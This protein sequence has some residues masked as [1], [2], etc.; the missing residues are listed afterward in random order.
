ME[1]AR[2]TIDF[3]AHQETAR[4]RSRR[5]VVM[6]IAAVV[7]ICGAVAAVAW[8]AA[9][10]VNDPRTE[11][12]ALAL[13]AGI[14]AL[15]TALTIIGGTLYRVAELRGGGATVAAAMGGVRLNASTRDADERR[16]LNVVEEMAIASGVPVP[17]VYLLPEEQGINAF[18]AGYHTGDAVIGVTRGCVQGLT[19]DELQGVMAH[20]FSHILNGDMRLNIRLIGLLYGIVLLSMTG[21]LIL[22]FV[23]RG[24]M[25]RRS[26]D[27]GAVLVAVIL[28]GITLVVIGAVGSLAARIIQAA[29][30]RQREFLADAA[31]VQFTRNPDGIAGAL[32]RIGGARSR[33]KVRHPRAQ[34]AGHMFFGEAIAG[35]S[36][37]GSMLASHP[38]LKERIGRVLP[39]WD[40]TML[41]PLVRVE[42]TAARTRETLNVPGAPGAGGGVPAGAAAMLPLLA[43]A[44]DATPAHVAHAR[45]LVA[46]IPTELKEAAHEAYGA[47]AVVYALLLDKRQRVRE[48]QQKHLDACADHG[49]AALTAVLAPKVAGLG[50]EL[51]LPLLEMALG[52]LADLSPEQHKVFR[53]NMRSLAEMDGETNIFEW[54]LLRVVN[55]HLDERFGGGKRAVTQYYSLG[56]LGGPVSVL[57]SAVAFAGAPD[58]ARAA[59]AF[60][61]GAGALDGVK[62]R[63]VARAACT[64]STLEEALTTLETVAPRLKVDLLKA[65]AL[66]AAA[67][68]TISPGEAELLRAVADSLGVPTPPLL[69][70]QRLV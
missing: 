16:V 47:R 41:P 27:A 26:K 59:R 69:P 63:L 19:R 70:G 12:T 52:G 37:F 44:G 34:E 15:L 45:G 11:W 18:A 7:L 10:L 14:A 24:L 28:I 35:E 65:C 1:H 58:E 30:S 9:A 60:L 29:V 3:F 48:A 55:K 4:S 5:L 61:I 42:P 2:T 6:Y 21:Y 50:W 8:Q 17:P 64:L 46:A 39:S 43:M 68:T 57:L 51:R 13:P 67:D 32:R 40:G 31:A 53:V 49:V 23:P 54:T 66:I 20:E 62:T 25:G 36:F 22:R 56:R 38:P 33:A